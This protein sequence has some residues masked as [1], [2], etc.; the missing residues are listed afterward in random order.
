M[1]KYLKTTFL[2]ITLKIFLI[3]HNLEES[4]LHSIQVHNTISFTCFLTALQ[5]C[6]LPILPVSLHTL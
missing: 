4:K 3:Q 1:F 5:I 6:L 2:K